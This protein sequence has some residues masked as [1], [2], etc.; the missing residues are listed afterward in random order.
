MKAKFLIALFLSFAFTATLIAQAGVSTA[1]IRV[2]TVKSGYGAKPVD[3]QD[4]FVHV[5]STTADGKEL[6]STRDM[7][8]AMH[9]VVG[10]DKDQ[11]SKATYDAM[12]SRMQR[13]GEYRLEVPKELITDKDQAASIDG[14]HIVYTIEM[15]DFANARPSGTQVIKDVITTKGIE[16]A[17]SRFRSLRT[18]ASYILA[19][20]DMNVAGYELLEAKKNDE[21]IAVFKMNTELSPDSWNAYDSLGDGYLAKG[22]NENAK[23]SFE[24]A[25]ELN[26]DY[27]ASREKLEKLR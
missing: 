20:W 27:T 15:I 26:P 1:N 16:A 11:L 10:R 5:R 9:G 24:K 19:E 17:Q 23:A 25:L 18:D 2:T 12:K 21:A 4:Y 6:F 13:G 8:V 3:G 22:D 7:N 14:D